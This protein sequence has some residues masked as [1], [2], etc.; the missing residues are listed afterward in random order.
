MIEIS[1]IE[2]AMLE[3]RGVKKIRFNMVKDG[4][5]FGF[6]RPVVPKGERR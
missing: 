4:S 2:M 3:D 1:R 5:I 6:I